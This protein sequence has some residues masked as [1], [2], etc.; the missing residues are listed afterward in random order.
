MT[1]QTQHAQSLQTARE[2]LREVCGL[3]EVP[4]S[5]RDRA[6][7]TLERL[8]PP[9][10]FKRPE[11]QSGLTWWIQLEST[12]TAS[13][14]LA[15]ALKD[16]RSP[17][18]WTAAV[19]TR[20][21]AG[22]ECVEALVC[23]ARD[24]RSMRDALAERVGSHVANVAAV[25]RGIGANEVTHGVITPDALQMAEELIRRREPFLLEARLEYYRR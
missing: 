15:A 17:A 3:A 22:K 11:A 20:S 10:Q 18:V 2:I 8:R 21:A 14:E 16:H 19:H 7:S 4:D 13:E 23:F 5:I 24:E 25:V 6:Q 9:G 1:P 12:S